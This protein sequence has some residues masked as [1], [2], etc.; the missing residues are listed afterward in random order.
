MQ[1]NLTNPP[2]VIDT[3]LLIS[4]MIS[5]NSIIHDVLK[6]ALD[7]YTICTSQ[8]TI[9]E[10]LEVARRDKFLRFF[11]DL[12]NREKFIELIIQSSKII[13]PTHHVTDCR[14]PK[15]NM[16]LDIALTCNA[17]YLVSGDKNLL[18][19]NPYKGVEIITATEF[20]ER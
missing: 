6:K 16:F 9:D 15:D 19:L 17:L 1:N 18:E 20:L 2:V 12:T 4:A 11:K 10:F 8:Q 5:P 3:N 7:E 13:E 14:D